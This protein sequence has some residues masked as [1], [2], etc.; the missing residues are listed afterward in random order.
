MINT[1]LVQKLWSLCDILRDDGISYSDYVAELTLLL[2]LKMEYE[3]AKSGVLE[4]HK[5]PAYARWDTVE[6]LSGEALLSQYREILQKLSQS[7]D[8]RLSAIYENSKTN[9][10]E[11]HHL[12]KIIKGIDSIDWFSAR[13]DGLGDLYEGLLEKNAA[14]VKSGAGQYFTPRPLIDCMVRVTQPMAGELIQDPAAGTAGFLIAAHMYVSEK[15]SNFEKLSTEQKKFQRQS[16]Y[17]GIELVQETRR[18]AL[19][20]CLLHGIEG[21]GDGAIQLG[22]TLS[23]LGSALPASDVIFSNPPFGTAKG[24][25]GPTRDDLRFSTGNKQLAFLQHIYQNLKQNGRAAVVLP[26]N[27]LFEAGLG[28]DIR[29][30]LM[31][32]CNLHTILRLPT[33][34]FYAQ[35]VKTNVLFFTKGTGEGSSA[36]KNVWFYDMRTNMPKFGRRTPFTKEYF[37]DFEKEYGK[38]SSGKSARHDRG[39][40]GRWRKFTRESIRENKDSLDI[41]WLKDDSVDQQSDLSTPEF[42][43]DKIT[44]DIESVLLDLRILMSSLDPKVPE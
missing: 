42:L 30:D 40:M 33:G 43:V 35:G 7:K 3:N 41:L 14:E 31:D 18:L 26:D 38:D 1:E 11:Y 17:V 21:K 44:Q 13:R 5:L 20:N 12:E 15:T 28:A 9:I 36:T 32:Q 27:V 34:I 6:S 39:D 23:S 4:A 29:R 2:F 10:K 25:G 16:A 37:N 24:G 8:L 22:N 19:M